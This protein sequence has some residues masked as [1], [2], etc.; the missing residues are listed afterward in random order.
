L[1]FTGGVYSLL[2][3]VRRSFDLFVARRWPQFREKITE[4]S[5][6]LVQLAA[7]LYLGR[8]VNIFENTIF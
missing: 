8:Q 2:P 4:I 3:I 6:N 1:A 7:E 5:E